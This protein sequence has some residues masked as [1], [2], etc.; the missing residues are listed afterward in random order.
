MT[1]RPLQQKLRNLLVDKMVD[2]KKELGSDQT[3]L[4]V[5]PGTEYN[6]VVVDTMKQLS[7]NICYVTANKTYDSLKELFV[8]NKVNVENVVFIDAISKSLKKVPDQGESVY[9]VSSPGALTELSLVVDKF[10]KHEFDYLVFD[11]I[12]NL[13][14]YQKV[15]MCAKFLTSLVD[16]IKKTKTKAVLYAIGS[17]KKDAIIDKVAMYV[18]SVVE[19]GGVVEV[20]SGVKGK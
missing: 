20:K 15:D 18:D 19:S 2:I 16:K 5:M 6:E 11:S 17:V 14:T 1:S 3:V 8:K 13:V 7:G 4:L 12:T 9:Y 10:L